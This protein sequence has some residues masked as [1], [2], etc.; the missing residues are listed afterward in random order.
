M[1]K[2]V[3]VGCDGSD[4]SL[5][6]VNWAIDNLNNDKT[7]FHFIHCFSPLE[8]FDLEDSAAYFPSEEEQQKYQEAHRKEFQEFLT[9]AIT[10]EV[11]KKVKYKTH[12]LPADPR[13]ILPKTA[14]E[15]KATCIVVGCTGKSTLTRMVLGS[16]SNDLAHSSPV[17]VIIVR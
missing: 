4:A 7:E 10:E 6:A 17:P 12:L 1:S 15:L 13:D 2:T 3:V 8:A 11:E 16:V 5:K 9:K 14:E